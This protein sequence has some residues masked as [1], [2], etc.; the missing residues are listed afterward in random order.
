MSSG[1]PSYIILERSLDAQLLV[2]GS[3]DFGMLL[4]GTFGGTTEKVIRGVR[5]SV[6]CVRDEDDQS[7][8]RQRHL[9]TVGSLKEQA[10]A[11]LETDA[12]RSE[13]L[14]RLAIQYAPTNAA[15]HQVLAEALERQG[16]KAAAE[17]VRAFGQEIRKT[18]R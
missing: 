4:P 8:Q 13:R 12:A 1:R 15:L 9:Q 18:C 17:A 6:L 2:L 14:I 7:Q 10:Q 16:K 3:R 5:C 11:S